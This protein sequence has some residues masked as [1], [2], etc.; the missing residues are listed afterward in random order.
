[1]SPQPPSALQD[2]RSRIRQIEM[3]GKTAGRVLPFGFPEIDGALP[4]GGRALG[5]VHEVVEGGDLGV[6]HAAAA[7]LFVAGVL[8]RMA[9]SVLWCL[10]AP[11]LFAPALSQVGLNASSWM[12]CHHPEVFA[13]ALLNAQPMGFYA[14]AQIVRDAREHG[15]EVRPV[16]VNRSRW[17][18][19][20][21]R[22][23]NG[24]LAV[25]LGFR[26]VKGLANAAGASIVGARE[27]RPYQCRGPVAARGRA[28]GSAAAAGCRRCLRW[29]GAPAPGSGMGHPGAA[30]RGAAAVRGGRCRAGSRGARGHPATH[31]RR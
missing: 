20:L 30:G 6:I 31:E 14:P 5:A 16:D 11:D 27:D 8:A 26:M 28:G 3:G 18:C 29:P 22:T 21:E 9:G 25:R 4:G 12:K 17:D 2:L 24:T 19:T 1:M 13:C 15:V 7:T 10:R 23:G